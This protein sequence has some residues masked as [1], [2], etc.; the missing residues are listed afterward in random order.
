MQ[1]CLKLRPGILQPKVNTGHNL[2]KY[3]I[4]TRIVSNSNKGDAYW[5]LL[6]TDWV[7][8]QKN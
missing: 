5:C 6:V 7:E 1:A 4:V 2:R 8:H 3:G